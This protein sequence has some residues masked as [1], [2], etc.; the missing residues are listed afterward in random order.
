MKKILLVVISLSL[1]LLLISEVIIVK[2]NHAVLRSGPGSFYPIISY[3]Q[4]QEE[5]DVIGREDGWL[6]VEYQGNHGYV[7]EKISKKKNRSEETGKKMAEEK[8]GIRIA[9]MGMTAGVKGFA[10]KLSKKL[11]SDPAFIDIFADYRINPK[12]FKK[13]KKDTYRKINY[14]KARRMNPLPTFDENDNYSFSERE[15]GLAIAS[16][17]ASLGLSQDTQQ[18]EY[19]NMFGNL[20]VSASDVYDHN[21]KFFILNI[22]NPNSYACPGGIIFVTSGLLSIIDNEAQLA[23]VLGH[24][25]THIARKH[26][27]K[28]TE[29]RLNQIMAENAFIELDD[30]LKDVGETQSEEET[31]T[32]NEMEDLVL[33][34]YEQIAAGRLGAYENEA[35]KI[36]LLYAI[37]AGFDPNE[38]LKLLDKMQNS[39]MQ[40]NNEHYSK[41]QIISRKIAIRKN[42]QKLRLP[43]KLIVNRE[44]YVSNIKK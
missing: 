28:E 42:L 2:R 15:L 39:E 44:R 35:D 9:R 8:T 21:F 31:A 7:S 17:I 34:T 37:R 4:P 10:K 43:K 11:D 14:K 27:M 25:I 40:S 13:F 36:G 24:E 38:M 33:E 5:L 16:K 12:E 30:E 6:E 22:P 29:K 32:E 3:L 20:I 18:T 1:A 19:L 41:E 23:C 26:G